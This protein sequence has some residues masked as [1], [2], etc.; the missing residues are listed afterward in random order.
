MCLLEFVR[1]PARLNDPGFDQIGYRVRRN[2]TNRNRLWERSAFPICIRN[3]AETSFRASGRGLRAT[4]NPMARSSELAA[5]SLIF[6]ASRAVEPGSFRE[7]IEC[8]GL[9]LNC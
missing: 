4:Q 9:H 6:E 8:E 7:I 1:Y 5:R 2:Q 3:G